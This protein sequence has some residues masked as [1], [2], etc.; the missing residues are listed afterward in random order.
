M[1]FPWPGYYLITKHTMKI[2]LLLLFIVLSPRLSAQATA[3]NSLFKNHREGY[4]MYRIPSVIKTGSGKLLAFC[5]GR[6]GLMDRGDIDLVMKSSEDNGNTW[7]SLKIIWD[8]GP[9]TCGN[10]SPVFD[11]VTGEVIVV[12]SLNNDK[13][14]V[15]RSKDEGG[16]WEQPRDITAAIKPGNWKWYATGPVHAIQLEQP[17]FKNRIVM[18]CNH[19][20]LDNGQHVSHVIYSDDHGMSW[21]LGGSVPNPKT[22]ECTVAELSGGALILNMRN[23]DRGLPHRKISMS[24]DGGVTWTGAV[25]DSTL[26]EPVCQG[27]LLRYSFTPDVL[28]FSNPWHKQKR[29]NLT[30]SISPDNGKSWA[31]QVTVFVGKSAYSDLVALNNGDVLCLFETGKLWPYAGI[32][33]KI[34]HRDR[35]IKQAD[36]QRCAPG[37]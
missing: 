19:T 4:K 11:K 37:K 12:A 22:D 33:F 8:M 29:K 28:L 36:S 24:S 30:L 27:S 10:P 20:T 21:Q 15:L 7:S 18:P 9:N 1:F 6:K 14:Y 23:N 3:I 2:S 5:E 17:T 32:S 35:I 26:I 16:H 25:F 13:V 31:K 34:I